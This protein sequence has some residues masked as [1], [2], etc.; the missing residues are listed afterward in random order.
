MFVMGGALLVTTPGFQAIA[1]GKWI[2]KPACAP[3]FSAPAV[4]QVDSKLLMGGI[5]F[6]AGWGISGMCPGPAVVS[7]VQP[8]QQLLAYVGAMMAGMAL[9]R[10]MAAK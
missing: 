10:R 8:S 5:L 2:P 4:T 3:C 6:G 7:L 1:R 9:E